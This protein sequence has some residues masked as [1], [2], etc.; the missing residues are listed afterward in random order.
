MRVAAKCASV[1]K[2]A[3]GNGSGRR[4]GARRGGAVG[5]GGDVIPAAP[6]P[7]CCCW[8][9]LGTRCLKGS[10]A[11]RAAVRVKSAVGR[12]HRRSLLGKPLEQMNEYK[13]GAWKRMWGLGYSNP[14]GGTVRAGEG[15]ESRCA[16]EHGHGDLN[17]GAAGNPGLGGV[18]RRKGAPGIEYRPGPLFFVLFFLSRVL[19]LTASVKPFPCPQHSAARHSTALR[20]PHAGTTALH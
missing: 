13:Q 3:W 2:A 12:R 15:S 11:R 19:L 6:T 10:A 7:G 17:A 16:S 20:R 18:S 4:G 5:R 14:R 9:R 1:H 8:T